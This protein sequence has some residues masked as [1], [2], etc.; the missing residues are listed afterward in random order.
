MAT[1]TVSTIAFQN[2]PT[3]T[4]SLAEADL[5]AVI[6]N[7]KTVR[8]PASSFAD[9]FVTYTNDTS[10]TPGAGTHSLAWT[11]TGIFA[12]NGS[13]WRMTPF[14]GPHWEDASETTRFLLVN[15]SGQGLSAIEQANA[16]A[17]LGISAAT[18][19][20]AGLVKIAENFED[21]GAV[22]TAAQ[23]VEYVAG[24]ASATVMFSIVPSVSSLPAT[25][26]SG[27]IYLVPNGDSTYTQYVWDTILRKYVVVGTSEISETSIVT[28]VS[29]QADARDV[30]NAKAVYDFVLNTANTYTASQN[31]AGG[32]AANSISVSGDAAAAPTGAGLWKNALSLQ[33]TTPSITFLRS[34]GVRGTL[35][36]AGAQLLLNGAALDT[37]TQRETAVTSAISTAK[38]YADN[39]IVDTVSGTDASH[40]PSG[41][42]VVAYV[43]S[44]IGSGGGS[45]GGGGGNT[46]VIYRQQLPS[47]GED[48]TVY[49]SPGLASGYT[50]ASTWLY[51]GGWVRAG[52]GQPTSTITSGDTRRVPSC[53]AV[54]SFVTSLLN[55]GGDNG[56][57]TNSDM[58]SYAL[59]KSSLMNY[60]A[61]QADPTNDVRPVTAKVVTEAVDTVKAG[62]TFGRTV[63]SK[64][65]EV[66]AG[67]NDEGG[68]IFH[69]RT[70]FS[71]SNSQDSFSVYQTAKFYSGLYVNGSFTGENAKF[72]SVNVSTL[73][74]SGTVR[75]SQVYGTLFSGA[76]LVE[77][78]KHWQQ[79][80]FLWSA[81]LG[82]YSCTIAA[83]SW[84]SKNVYVSQS[85]GTESSRH[86]IFY[87]V[88]DAAA[89]NTMV[90]ADML[91]G[92]RLTVYPAST[93]MSYTAAWDGYV[94]GYTGS[95][96]RV[97]MKLGYA[98]YWSTKAGAVEVTPMAGM[99]DASYST[100][101]LIGGGSG[102]PYSTLQVFSGGFSSNGPVTIDGST[103]GS[104]TLRGGASIGGS[105]TS[106]VYLSG[107]VIVDP[108]YDSLGGYEFQCRSAAD[109]NKEIRVGG[110]GNF[111]GA[112]NVYGIATFYSG[113]SF[114][115]PVEFSGIT[116]FYDVSYFHNAGGIFGYTTTFNAATAFYST[117][118]FDSVVSVQNT[119][120]IQVRPT[121]VRGVGI[122][123]MCIYR[124][125]QPIGVSEYVYYSC[126]ASGTT[127]SAGP[128]LL[129][130]N[131]IIKVQNPWSASISTWFGYSGQQSYSTLGVK[132]I[133]LTVDT[134]GIRP[135]ALMPS[136][137][138]HYHNGISRAISEATV[139]IGD[140]KLDF[141]YKESNP[142]FMFDPE[143]I[144][145]V[146]GLTAGTVINIAY[147]YSGISTYYSDVAIVEKAGLPVAL[148]FAWSYSGQPKLVYGV[149]ASVDAD[150]GVTYLHKD[151]PSRTYLGGGILLW[152]PTGD[153]T[154]LLYNTTAGYRI[155][156]LHNLVIIT[157][158]K[159]RNDLSWGPS[160]VRFADGVTETQK[161]YVTNYVAGTIVFVHVSN[162]GG[163]YIVGSI[164]RI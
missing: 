52:I 127:A 60:S 152:C 142:D 137:L 27:Y 4:A 77:Q 111:S 138:A 55:Q 92:T 23:M 47:V 17:N 162:I 13:Q 120:G 63:F 1:T 153:D 104:V 61:Y 25:P 10:S 51:S 99:I 135:D 89:T 132:T 78:R 22:V 76:A 50:D 5:V 33:G 56:F 75:A 24:S 141:S 18:T 113:A 46:N 38:D 21:S 72:S 161:A 88:S 45:G 34:D 100:S 84:S 136:Q 93:G 164:R 158:A 62:G 65:F 16:R 109:F 35:S 32:I 82:V 64:G 29:A 108:Y 98:G 87:S 36:F 44:R 69:G 91:P 7:S 12:F 121:S 58:K 43:D 106:P 110:T 83:E 117:A 163:I 144:P 81:G 95:S 114:S 94:G 20:T 42:A 134:M 139:L 41:K 73:E 2:L 96:V 68:T 71:S 6:N 125:S 97:Q 122:S 156:G 49:I 79:G 11:T 86:V 30:P 149:N 26:A 103:G 159:D 28:Y 129:Y 102:S 131:A 115:G 133:N 145:W 118:Y 116:R 124:F 143:D 15:K 105:P 39:K 148:R 59:P 90:I 14:Y 150:Y 147:T 80:S 85:S 128:I 54:Y 146:G 101:K 140:A 57:V 40:A 3:T 66:E 70:T 157:A 130:P 74:A 160:G 119:S 37:V 107:S 151:R 67:T 53:G 154:A 19:T 31:F 48:N 8:V 123:D 9:G 112:L 126:T 155:N